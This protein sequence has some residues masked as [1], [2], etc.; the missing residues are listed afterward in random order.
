MNKYI[1]EFGLKKV[2]NASAD[3]D[4]EPEVAISNGFLT[5]NKVAT[6]IIN[7]KV[8]PWVEV[9]TGEQGGA[10]IFA[11]SF[12]VEPTLDCVEAKVAKKGTTRVSLK[13]PLKKHSYS[14]KGG[15]NVQVIDIDKTALVFSI[16]TVRKPK[17]EPEENQPERTTRPAPFGQMTT[18]RESFDEDGK[19]IGSAGVDG[20]IGVPFADSDF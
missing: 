4:K 10:T 12:N 18:T 6:D 14:L 9:F 17:E 13:V 8:S 3:P 19:S 20:G 2:R 15:I 1:E 7:P 11:L 5:L 16:G